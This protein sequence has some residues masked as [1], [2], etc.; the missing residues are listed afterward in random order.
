MTTVRTTLVERLAADF[1]HHDAEFDP[2][3]AIEVHRVI[4]ERGRVAFSRAHGGMWVLSHHADVLAALRDHRTFSSGAGVFFPRARAAPRFAPLEYD[5]PEHTE[6]RNLMKPPFATAAVRHLETAVRDE[7]SAALAPMLARSHGDLV[8]ELCVPLPIAAVSHAVG[9]SA[10]AQRRIRRLTSDTWA[11]MSTDDGAES[12]WPQF[13]ALLQS[14]IDRVRAQP[15]DDYLS[16]VVR[17]EIDGQPVTDATLRGLLVSF[18]IAG[19]ETTMNTLAHLLWQLARDADLQDRLRSEPELMPAVI[20]ETLRLWTPVDHGTRLTT[21]AVQIDGTTIPAGARVVMLAGAANR[22]PSVFAD[23]DDFRPDRA[24]AG[25]LTFG[26]GVHA[27]VGARL[28][29]LELLAVLRELARHPSYELTRPAR[30]YYEA[31]RHICIDA[32]V[33]RFRSER[34]GPLP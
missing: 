21:R 20:N 26:T 33:V 30:R 16:T 7:V 23:P 9:F 1:D 14:E 6:L 4:R 15:G 19:H 8:A 25:H 28:A 17:S 10:D 11:G 2:D 5:P 12:F 18:A 31:G 32:L 22:D 24:R 13:A 34:R 29:R 3:V 27:C